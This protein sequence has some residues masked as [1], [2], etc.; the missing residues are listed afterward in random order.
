M[1]LVVG[2][3][4]SWFSQSSYPIVRPPEKVVILFRE[5]D[6]LA[7][8]GTEGS[9]VQIHSPRPLFRGLFRSHG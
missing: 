9:V 7:R 3:G 8:F 4:R 2:G 5:V 6:T 1:W